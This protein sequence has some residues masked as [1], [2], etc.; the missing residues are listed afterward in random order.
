MKFNHREF[1]LEPAY[2]S[3]IQHALR[4][5]MKVVSHSEFCTIYPVQ[6]KAGIWGLRDWPLRTQYIHP[7]A[8]APEC[9]SW[10]PLPSTTCF[11]IAWLW[12][13]LWELHASLKHSCELPQCFCQ[14]CRVA[15]PLHQWDTSQTYYHH[16]LKTTTLNFV[17]SQL[18]AVM[19]RH[20]YKMIIRVSRG[21]A[22][23]TK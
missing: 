1:A 19:K 20:C 16:S 7:W 10:T 2:I 4:R 14:K 11:W 8:K 22:N 3:I 17:P 13:A 18:S 6:S 9:G 12:T 5:I 21:M 23:C 15:F